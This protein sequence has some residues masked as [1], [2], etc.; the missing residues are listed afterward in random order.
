[1]TRY[2][3]VIDESFN[4]GVQ[5]TIWELERRLNQRYSNGAKKDAIGVAFATFKYIE[6]VK[7]ELREVSYG[8]STSVSNTS[9]I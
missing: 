3:T 4:L 6:D 9:Y 2:K 7:K 5:H 8:Q 1:M